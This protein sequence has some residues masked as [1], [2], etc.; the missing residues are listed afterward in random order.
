MEVGLAAIPN[1]SRII[2]QLRSSRNSE[3]GMIRETPAK[4]RRESTPVE[5]QQL[6]IVLEG[7]AAKSLTT[8]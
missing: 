7:K 8:Y 5:S 2:E 6:N 4:R 3:S 1:I